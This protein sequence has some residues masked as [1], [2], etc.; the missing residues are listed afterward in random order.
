MIQH[1]ANV[2]F[3]KLTRDDMNAPASANLL[4]PTIVLR[5]FTLILFHL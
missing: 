1:D 3:G 4:A 5:E 2:V